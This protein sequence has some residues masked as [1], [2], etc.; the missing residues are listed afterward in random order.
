MWP[1]STRS[2]PLAFSNENVLR[3]V[4]QGELLLELDQR[5]QHEWSGDVGRI[6]GAAKA[7][8]EQSFKQAVLS[9]SL[10]GGAGA[11]WE[12]ANDSE[13]F[14]AMRDERLLG[15]ID[16]IERIGIRNGRI[17]QVAQSLALNSRSN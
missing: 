11:L 6:L 7:K 15:F 14:N 12:E 10:F 1:F 8:D 4:N 13:V 9:R 17:R 16:A 3:L 5:R 2:K